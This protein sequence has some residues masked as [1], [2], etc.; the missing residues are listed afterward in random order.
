ME[1]VTE[2]RVVEVVVE[3]VS[4]WTCRGGCGD[5][6]FSCPV[7]WLMAATEVA[8]LVRSSRSAAAED[9]RSMRLLDI[10]LVVGLRVVVIVVPGCC[11]NRLVLLC[12]SGRVG[13]DGRSGNGF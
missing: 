4:V 8:S 2:D 6:W 5:L 7:C 1:V 11:G 10:L 3:V 9:A 12:A 13:G